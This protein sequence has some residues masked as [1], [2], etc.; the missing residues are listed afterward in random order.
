LLRDDVE[1]EM[2]PIATW[3]RGRKDVLAFYEFRAL[4]LQGRPI[5]ATSA[6]GYP[7]AASYTLRGDGA[8][9]PHSIQVLEIR[10]GAIAHI[11]AFLDSDLYPMFG[12]PTTLPIVG[13][14]S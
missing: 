2:P 4:A 13:V 6:N 3:F 9:T 14:T 10:N 12:L 1:L 5:L 8:W 11:H 7:A